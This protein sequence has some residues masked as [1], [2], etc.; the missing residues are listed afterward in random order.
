MQ[1]SRPRAYLV[2]ESHRNRILNTTVYISRR[3]AMF[4]FHL[5]GSPPKLPRVVEALIW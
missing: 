2:V 5:D 4:H 3:E 1:C